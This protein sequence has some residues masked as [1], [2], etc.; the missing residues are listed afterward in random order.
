VR[1]DGWHADGFGI[2]RDHEVRGLAD[3][4]T[5]FLGPN[6]AGKSTLLAFLRGVLVGYPARGAATHYP[7][8][9]GGE[10]GG[11][12]FLRGSEGEV[13]V[14]RMVRSKGPRVVFPDRV[15]TGDEVVRRLLGG[16]DAGL[17]SSVFAFSLDELQD[18]RSLSGEGV[19]DRIFSAGIVGAGRSARHVVARLEK[20]A[21]DLLRPRKGGRANGLMDLLA[22]SESRTA[23]AR[24]A[25]SHYPRVLEAEAEA[26]DLVETAQMEVRALREALRRNERLLEI[27]PAYYDG[28]A[29]RGEL[30]SLGSVDGLPDDPEER[31]AL[32]IGGVATA[33][34][35]VA[36]LEVDVAE[37]RR[38]VEAGRAALRADL[39]ALSPSVDDL[40]DRLGVYQ[41]RVASLPEAQAAAAQAAGLAARHLAALG[42]DWDEDRLLAFDISLPRVEEVREWGARLAASAADLETRA[43]DRDGARGRLAEAEGERDRLRLRVEEADPA[44]DERLREE[45]AAL[46]RLRADAQDA[47]ALEAKIEGLRGLAMDRDRSLRVAEGAAEAG[48]IRPAG[49][50]LALIALVAFGCA[51]VLGVVV[52][53]VWAVALGVSA[54]VVGVAAYFAWKLSA[55]GGRSQAEILGLREALDMVRAD[56]T[57]VEARAEEVAGRMGVDA[58]TVGLAS[59]PSFADIES[60]VE[61]LDAARDRRRVREEQRS[62][63]EEAEEL[64][65]RAADLAASADALLGEVVAEDARLRREWCD[66]KAAVGVPV[67]LG[68]EGVAE[69]LRAASAARSAL[70]MRAETTGR[71]E[72]LVAEI[73]E[74]EVDARAVLADVGGGGEA[75]G[76]AMPLELRRLREACLADRAQRERYEEAETGLKKIEARLAIAHEALRRAQEERDTL[77]RESGVKD[78]AEFRERIALLGKHRRLEELIVAA[79]RAVDTRLGQGPDAIEV[80]E[81]LARG[82]VDSWTTAAQEL[83]EALAKREDEATDAIRLHR[84]AERNRQALEESSDVVACELELGGL[85]TELETALRRWQVV[86][87]AR[88]LIEETLAEYSRTRQ[89]PV[90][91]EA[92]VD[93]ARVTGGA[94]TQILERDDAEGF[95]VL[96]SCGGVKAPEHLSRGTLEQL[97]LSLRLGLAAEFARRAGAV[98]VIMDDV[99]V[100]FDPVRARATA[101]VLVSFAAEHQ[102]LFF[103]CHPATAELLQ[104]VDGGISVVDLGPKSGRL[105]TLWET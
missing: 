67:E 38:E 87:A 101:E 7:P 75:A 56:L 90:L 13:I 19:R 97:Y 10:H 98:P 42:P 48:G 4:L 26:F 60:R 35:Q 1:I 11:R 41:D 88:V 80:R 93:L 85:R 81:E 34:G 53:A 20:D 68:P 43:R 95:V 102:L 17:F 89:P 55:S 61:A 58:L 46:R 104:E 82:R 47:R 83:R 15:D 39:E 25:A 70:E 21:S 24:A 28:E 12:V 32:V 99:L 92:S 6:E 2:L 71:A 66:W 78:E 100:N 84:D 9:N 91:T 36:E 50:L 51:V 57:T 76:T 69:F 8:L 23:A 22:E 40:T 59:R 33:S 16:V 3:G 79:K 31:L 103:T 65:S 14:E 74:W 5:V 64:A 54:V 45:E 72:R 77:F 73:E 37:A 27:W 49:R 52:D 18:L 29:A 96:D 63:A 62:R 86:T 105:D 94:Y 30:E 44:E